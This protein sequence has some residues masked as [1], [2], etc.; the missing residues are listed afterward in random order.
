MHKQPH[1][2]AMV[3]KTIRPSRSDAAATSIG[4]ATPF[5][6][7]MD[8]GAPLDPITVAITAAVVAA[9]GLVTKTLLIGLAGGLRA[10]RRHTRK[11]KSTKDDIVGEFAGGMGD[12]IDREHAE[13]RL[14]LAQPPEN[15]KDKQP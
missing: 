5:L 10:V 4:L 11:T 12:A 15:E 1:T 13:P 3:V 6:M 8:G 7:A 2:L 14:T 9:V